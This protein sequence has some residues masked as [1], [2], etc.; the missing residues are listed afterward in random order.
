MGVQKD[1]AAS[2]FGV[3]EH[4]ELEER[5][6]ARASLADHVEVVATGLFRDTK[7]APAIAPVGSAKDG[8][9]KTIGHSISVAQVEA[10]E[11]ALGITSYDI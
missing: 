6:L 7:R 9:K 1:E 8:E 10:H 5:R 3:L 2:G 11:K 4:E